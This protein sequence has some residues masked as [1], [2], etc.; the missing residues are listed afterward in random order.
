MFQ[1]DMRSLSVV[2]EPVLWSSVTAP[3]TVLFCLQ[4]GYMCINCALYVIAPHLPTAQM[5]CETN[6]RISSYDAE[7]FKCLIIKIKVCTKYHKCFSGFFS[8]KCNL[9]SRSLT[10]NEIRFHYIASFIHLHQNF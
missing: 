10:M 3:G 5:L 7:K 8:F 9:A 1:Y 6:Y 4:C 2:V